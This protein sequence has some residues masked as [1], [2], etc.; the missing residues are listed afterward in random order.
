MPLKER[1]DKLIFS[2]GLAP[3]RERAQA[4]IMAGKVLVNEQKAEKPGQKFTKDSNIRLI[5]TDQ[6]FVSRGGLKLA[7]AIQVFK[8]TQLIRTNHGN[9]KHT[10]P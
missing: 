10:S 6:P 1:I 4:Y 7:K 8:R 2:R 5:G 9:S 3:S